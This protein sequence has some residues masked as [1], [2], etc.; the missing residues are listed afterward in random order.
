MAIQDDLTEAKHA[1]LHAQR[2]RQAHRRRT[3]KGAPQR[4]DDI[5]L[6]L[7]RLKDAMR[8]LRSYIGR[9]PFSQ[10]PDHEVLSVRVASLMIQKERR[11]LWKMQK[12]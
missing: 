9:L 10:P 7:E 5:R 1:V 12:R 3:S 8:P 2:V 11:K 6:A 4:E